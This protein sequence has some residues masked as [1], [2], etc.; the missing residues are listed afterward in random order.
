M[1]EKKT[2]TIILRVDG[3]LRKA[4]DE[5]A[6]KNGKSRASVV[7]DAVEKELSNGKADGSDS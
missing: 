7:R 3:P 4:I 1:S 6:R 2:K 5:K